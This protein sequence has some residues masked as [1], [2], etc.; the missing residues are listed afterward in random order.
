MSEDTYVSVF[1]IDAG[2]NPTTKTF[3]YSY[4]ATKQI[5]LVLYPFPECTMPGYVAAFPWSQVYSLYCSSTTGKIGKLIDDIFP[6][7][8]DNLYAPHG[9][10]DRLWPLVTHA[11]TSEQF[12]PCDLINEPMHLLTPECLRTIKFAWVDINN[13]MYSPFFQARLDMLPNLKT[14]KLRGSYTPVQSPVKHLTLDTLQLHVVN[15]DWIGDLIQFL[16]SWLGDKLELPTLEDVQ[17]ILYENV[18]ESSSAY[19]KLCLVCTIRGLLSRHPLIRR[20]RLSDN[21]ILNDQLVSML[22]THRCLLMLLGSLEF[23]L[24]RELIRKLSEHLG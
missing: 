16:R 22:T 2:Y 19:E 6:R 24:P 18:L 15:V 11:W 21:Q 8:K 1:G 3:D 7:I 20:F 23:P 14:L 5:H 10:P 13:D 9:L 4:L 17:C 12:L